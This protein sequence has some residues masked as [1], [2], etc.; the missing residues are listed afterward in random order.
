M[1][2]ATSDD[3]PLAAL[4]CHPRNALTPSTTNPKQDFRPPADILPIF[5]LIFFLGTPVLQTIALLHIGVTVGS[6]ILQFYRQ[7]VAH[8]EG[9]EAEAM[10][11]KAA[12]AAGS[13]E[14]EAGGYA[15][16][17][18]P[19]TTGERS[20]G[21][22]R[23]SSGTGFL[24]E[25]G[26]AAADGPTVVVVHGGTGGGADDGP[27]VGWGSRV[28]AT[29][30]PTAACGSSS[31]GRGSPPLGGAGSLSPMARTAAG[32][33]MPLRSGSSSSNGSSGRPA[34]GPLG[35][36]QPS[37]FKRFTGRRQKPAP[38]RPALRQVHMQ[39]LS[40]IY[41]V[42][43]KSR[44][45][46]AAAA[47]RNSMAA[48]ASPAPPAGAEGAAAAVLG[49]EGAEQEG[50]VS[51]GERK[52]AVSS[53]GDDGSSSGDSSGGKSVR[54]SDVATLQQNALLKE[55]LG[56]KMRGSSGGSSSSS[57]NSSV[58]GSSSLLSGSAA[59]SLSGDASGS[60]GGAEGKARA[61]GPYASYFPWRSL[62]RSRSM[63][64][65][66]N[67]EISSLT[68][69]QDYQISSLG[70][71][72]ALTPWGQ[73]ALSPA[74]PVKRGVGAGRGG[75][76]LLLS[77][78][79]EGGTSSENPSSSSA[80]GHQQDDSMDSWAEH[81][82]QHGGGNKNNADVFVGGGG[83]GGA[84]YGGGASVAGMAHVSES[85]AGSSEASLVSD[86]GRSIV[87]ESDYKEWMQIQQKGQQGPPGSQQQQQ[88]QQQQQHQHQ[89]Q[90]AEM[91]N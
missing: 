80:S 28:L 46:D 14:E 5:A 49:G 64:Q 85:S 70:T 8:Y 34:P 50:V 13:A 17:L 81:G 55:M 43:F 37:A 35:V 56:V 86:G 83:G 66:D 71:S 82:P 87:T 27:A 88:Q 75:L 21:A 45:R 19:G 2:R 84:A 4:P 38:P 11:A 6:N 89:Q 76:R 32:S 44:G 24:Y 36:P 47:F 29:T 22:A 15:I 74:R 1:M 77:V 90:V 78:D 68:D 69:A 9:E 10:E 41:E 58:S 79:D 25:Q 26:A 57:S 3:R 40:T 73:K 42:A 52:S 23:S 51:G 62:V 72:P 39:A 30:P 33:A 53:D 63:S 65:A 67:S 31:G 18:T 20:D 7:Y 91:P 54:A 59:S 60:S 12:V 61:G 16:E 48:S